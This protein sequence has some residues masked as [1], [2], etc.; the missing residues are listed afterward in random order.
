[1]EKRGLIDEFKNIILKGSTNQIKMFDKLGVS[2]IQG[3]LKY[4]INIG[5]RAYFSSDIDTF[6]YFIESLFNIINVENKKVEND[7]LIE[8]VYHYGLISI[9]NFNTAL[10]FIIVKQLKINIYELKET[11]YIN[12][13][14]FILKNLALKSGLNNFESGV[15]EIINIF[16]D[17][18]EYFIN[19]DMKINRFY[20]KSIMISLIYSAE[21]NQQKSLK[22]KMCVDF[23]TAVV[24]D[25]SS[26]SRTS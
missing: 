7:E 2:T 26:A 16:K 18:N 8:Q 21:K 3:V 11:K 23:S 19:N 6:E 12:E 20:L 1:M 25:W 5:N 10:Y 13:Y 22:N 14:L 17:L 4:F 24:V 15:L 9:H